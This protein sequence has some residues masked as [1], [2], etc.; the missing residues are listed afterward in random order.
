MAARVNPFKPTAG[1]NPPELIGRD[2]IQDAPLDEMRELG[3]EIQ[4]LVRQGANV[5]FAFAGL[6]ASV[7]GV[8]VGEALTFLQRAKHIELKRLMD[9]EVGDS[10]EDTMVR[11]GKSVAPGVSD[12][13][14]AAAAGYPFMVQLVGYYTWQAASRRSSDMVELCVQCLHIGPY[15][16]EPVTVELMRAFAEEQGC[17]EDFSDERLHHE[18]YLNDA[19]RTAPEKLKT[20]IRHP[21]RRA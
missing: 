2:E 1:M 12:S 11:A 4:L 16:D 10:F 6:P 21:I 8:V 18:I 3:N 14:T 13:L 9:F 17:V 20:V 15:D 19:R 5:A 7:D